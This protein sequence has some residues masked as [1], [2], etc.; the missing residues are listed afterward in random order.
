MPKAKKLKEFNLPSEDNYKQLCVWE[1]TLVTEANSKEFE[2]FILEQTGSRIKYSEEI[3]TNPTPGE[4][5]TGGRNDVLFFIHKDD[6]AKFA[7]ARFTFGIRWWE[8]VIK[9]NNGSYLYPSEILI[10]YPV[11]W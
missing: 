4:P 8:D 7:V 9:Y 3:K 6:V 10:K 5:E 1:G 2:K 11:L